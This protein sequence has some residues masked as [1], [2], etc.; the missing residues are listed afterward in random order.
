M[1]LEWIKEAASLQKGASFTEKCIFD[2]SLNST[3][4]GVQTEHDV[5]RQGA[6][7]RII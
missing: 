7:S 5:N 1:R 2:V 4:T 3:W 6:I